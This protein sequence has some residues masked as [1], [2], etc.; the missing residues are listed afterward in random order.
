M[1]LTLTS[2]EVKLLV[3]VYKL[4]P[5]IKL[6]NI[7][8]KLNIGL[9]RLVAHQFANRYSEVQYCDFEQ[10]ASIALIKS[11]DL[12][13]VEG[14]ASFSNYSITYIKGHLQ[15]YIRDKRQLIRVPQKVHDL[16][17]A[18]KKLT[19]TENL[20]VLEIA[21]KLNSTEQ[22]VR[23]AMCLKQ[24]IG[25]FSADKLDNSSVD[26]QEENYYHYETYLP[27]K[28]IEELIDSGLKNKELWD[29]I[30]EIA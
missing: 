18:V 6:R 30:N 21:D 10:E 11:I 15:H 4:N 27:R 1:S 20:T 19:L 5:T 24:V 16:H 3:E 28:E 13:Q 2:D 22:K 8:A 14:G 7:I 12:F 26:Q 9:A 29:A 17:K 25:N 23:E